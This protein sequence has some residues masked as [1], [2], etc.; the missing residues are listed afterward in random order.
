[1]ISPRL[2]HEAGHCGLTYAWPPRQVGHDPAQDAA[3][4]S[5][6]RVEAEKAARACMENQF[7]ASRISATG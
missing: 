2:Y 5:L 4:L 1:M 6:F 3:E 7:V